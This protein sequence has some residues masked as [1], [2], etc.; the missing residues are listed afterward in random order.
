MPSCGRQ[1]ITATVIIVTENSDQSTPDE[2]D[3]IRAINIEVPGADETRYV[4][5]KLPAD[6]YN[7]LV[8]LK[9]DHGLTWRG[10]LMYARRELNGLPDGAD[11]D[12]VGQYQLVNETRKRHGFTWKGMLLFAARDLRKEPQKEINSTELN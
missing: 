3:D 11:I 1:G 7:M 9:D 5:T 4:S 8:D 12:E 6:Q 2:D 10:L